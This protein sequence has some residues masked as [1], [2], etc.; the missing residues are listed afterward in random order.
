MIRLVLKSS[1]TQTALERAAEAARDMEPIMRAAGTTL[2]SITLG[3][4]NRV[5]A[6]FRPI[7]WVPKYDGSEATLKRTGLLSSS[8][9]LEVAGNRAELSNPTPYAAI[10]QFGGQT[11]P[12]EIRATNKRALAFTLRDGTRIVARSVKHPGSKIPARPFIPITPDAE[13]T[14]AADR[15]IA[16]AMERELEKQ[17]GARQ[18]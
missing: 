16:S 17:I 5:G 1:D 12:H 18:T 9:R 15:L 3:N 14:S 4:F 11:A 13:L 7:P 8:F 10:H 2:L 6:D